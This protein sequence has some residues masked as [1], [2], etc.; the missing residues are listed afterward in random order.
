M[1]APAGSAGAAHRVPLPGL[2]GSGGLS[3]PFPRRLPTDTG[4]KVIQ[5]PDR[6]DQ[7]YEDH[8][9]HVERHLPDE[10]ILIIV[11]DCDVLPGHCQPSRHS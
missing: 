7:D 2:D 4:H 9:D 5:Y 11:A 3:G 1:A 8:A 10:N 6:P